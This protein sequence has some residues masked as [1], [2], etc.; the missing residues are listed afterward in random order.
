[1]FRIHR[2][3]QRNNTDVKGNRLQCWYLICRHQS[4]V[5]K[6]TQTNFEMNKETDMLEYVVQT[7]SPAEHVEVHN[8]YL[9]GLLWLGC[10][11]QND[12]EQ[13]ARQTTSP[14]AFFRSWSWSKLAGH[15]RI[16]SNSSVNTFLCI[17]GKLD[18]SKLPW[19]G[20][21]KWSG[22]NL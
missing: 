13:V 8:D 3:G 19:R 5:W 22:R 7:Y 18:T 21:Q 11:W 1:V 12:L 6:V 16:F 14:H 10:W 17:W 20:V 4:I 2:S 9:F 15:L